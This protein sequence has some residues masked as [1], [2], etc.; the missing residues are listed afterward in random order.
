MHLINWKRVCTPKQWGGLGLRTMRDMNQVSMMKE[1]WNLISNKDYM[2]VEVIKSN[3]ICGR[4]PIPRINTDMPGSNFWRGICHSWK[5]VE[6]KLIWRIGPGAM[7]N[8][9]KDRWILRPKKKKRQMDT[10]WNYFEGSD[11]SKRMS[12]TLDYVTLSLLVAVR[13]WSALRRSTIVSCPWTPPQKK[14]MVF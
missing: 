9:W 3:Y 10:K 11:L 7:I 6:S 12:A 5:G 1:G 14:W 13:T 2:W 8:F 4:S